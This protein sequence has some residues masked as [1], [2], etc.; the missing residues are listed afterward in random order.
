M[1]SFDINLTEATS[2]ILRIRQ[3]SDTAAQRLAVTLSNHPTLNEELDM[4]L[5]DLDEDPPEYFEEPEVPKMEIRVPD[6]SDYLVPIPF[7]EAL[8]DENEVV[9]TN[10]VRDNPDD[11]SKYLQVLA[12]VGFPLK[13]SLVSCEKT[14]SHNFRFALPDGT[15]IPSTPMGEEV[16]AIFRNYDRQEPPD[17]LPL[18]QR[19]GPTPVRDTGPRTLDMSKTIGHIIDLS[20][21]E[22]QY[23]TAAQAAMIEPSVNEEGFSQNDIRR[24]EI[25]FRNMGPRKR[26]ETLREVFHT[27]PSKRKDFSI[28]SLNVEGVTLLLYKGRAVAFGWTHKLPRKPDYRLRAISPNRVLEEVRCPEATNM[29]G[30]LSHTVPL[31]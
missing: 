2:I 29:Y 3:M 21:G 9:F 17:E 27:E 8:I 19:I 18:G 22:G 15:P 16:V 1:P 31:T 28:H 23:I 6:N 20:L 26:L 25:Y 11:A 14:E 12:N 30:I 10:F 7:I 24:C 4:L 5:E 13:E